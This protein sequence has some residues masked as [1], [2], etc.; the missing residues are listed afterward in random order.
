MDRMSLPT[1]DLEQVMGSL[2]R[3]EASQRP[4]WFDPKH[5]PKPEP[6]RIAEVAG[7]KYERYALWRASVRLDME[8]L[9]FERQGIFKN[10]LDAYRAG[11]LD[12]FQSV[13]LVEDFNLAVSIISGIT[14]YFPVPLTSDDD[15]CY[16]RQKRAAVEWLYKVGQAQVDRMGDLPAN[17]LP[18]KY[19][20][21]WGTLVK[22]VTLNPA[23]ETGESPFIEV[24]IDPTEI[25]VD[26]EGER[27]PK[28]V[29]RV[30]SSTVGDL[31][32][33]YGDFTPGVHKALADKYGQLDDE[34]ELENIVEYWDRQYR[35][36]TIGG[37]VILPVTKHDYLEP[38]FIIQPGPLGMPRSASLPAGAGWENASPEDRRKKIQH[39]SI[40][41]IGFKRVVHLQN[42]A[43]MKRLLLDEQRRNNPPIER[44]RSSRMA[45][46]AK[47][48]GF[49]PGDVNETALGEEQARVL[50]NPPPGPSAQLLATQ[51]MRDM[52]V[53]F[54]SP[55]AHGNTPDA[56]NISGTAQRSAL[57]Q[58][59]N[60]YRPWISAYQT[61]IRKESEFKLRQLR[62]NSDAIE[63]GVVGRVK[64]IVVP[65]TRKTSGESATVRLDRQLIERTGTDVEV[66]MTVRDK[67]SWPMLVQV[68][69]VMHQQLGVPADWLLDEFFQI[70]MDD[71]MR[72]EQDEERAL[73]AMQEHPKFME[74]FIIPARIKSEIAEN[75][76]HN[77]EYTQFLEEALAAWQQYIAQPQSGQGPQ[78]PP[79]A[80]PPDEPI[81]NP[82]SSEGMAF[83]ELGQGP[84]SVTGVM[85]GPRGPVGPRETPTMIGA[86]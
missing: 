72:E 18:V 9:R 26:W 5:Y 56:A 24:Y 43:W 74:L 40:S 77:P 71:A 23:A 78:G 14:P 84:G 20:L 68:A 38:P 1:L 64:P 62:N 44:A 32:A 67:D 27:G 79:P 7:Q 33:A 69:T 83:Q 54:A 13:M 85:G 52:A 30:F 15:A 22:R 82:P 11:F 51:I 21:G 63:Y 46:V 65:M 8:L 70:P 25:V 3:Y 17:I 31:C 86:L 2:Q 58:G 45:G 42:E 60:A 75:A 61:A 57:S 80:G 6:G 55:E 29:Y 10:D 66:R 50:Q 73:R 28:R 81:M 48:F 53:S 49:M 34:T 76:G 12:D 47:P 35:L 4:S 36:V 59:M 16:A 39:Q 41:Y 19:L 37:E